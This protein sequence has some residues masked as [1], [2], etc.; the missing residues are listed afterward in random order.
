MQTF[1][2]QTGGTAFIPKFSPID[3]KDS[4][5]NESNVKKN[6]AALDQIFHQLESELRAQYL[7]QYYPEA[8]YPN[9]KFVTLDVGLTNPTGRKVRARQG[10][11]FKR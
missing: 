3:T 2:S 1:A 5:Q 8:E 9:G 10:Y 4:F 7:V 6:Q 11:Y